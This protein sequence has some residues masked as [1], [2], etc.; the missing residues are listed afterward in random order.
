MLGPVSRHTPVVQSI[1]CVIETSFYSGNERHVMSH[2]FFF[3]FTV[4]TFCTWPHSHSVRL[5]CTDPQKVY[6]T[7]VTWG[8]SAC[9]GQ[10]CCPNNTVCTTEAHPQ[11]FQYVK[12]QCD[13]RQTCV[14]EFV[15]GTC[16]RPNGGAT[17]YE[18]VHYVCTS[19]YTSEFTMQRFFS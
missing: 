10:M 2:C 8:Q 9:P 17:D 18:S 1:F 13:G 3:L 7:N 16:E 12:K 19:T 6:I 14:T 4:T 5:T 15:P 11:H